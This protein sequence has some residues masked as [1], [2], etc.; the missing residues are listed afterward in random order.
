MRHQNI[1]Y[2]FMRGLKEK[3]RALECIQTLSIFSTKNR[4]LY[5]YK[6][7]YISL[8]ITTKQKPTVDTQKIIRKEST[9]STKENHHTKTEIK[10]RRKQQRNYKR[11]RKH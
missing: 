3:C 2:G 9:H 7:L 6:L 4:L 1:K 10:T 11:A 5:K 8:M